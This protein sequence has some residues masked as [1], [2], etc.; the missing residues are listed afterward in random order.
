MREVLANVKAVAALDHSAPMGAMGML[1]NE[2]AGAMVSTQDRPL[3]TN[4]IY[5]LGG[6]DFAVDEAKRI[7]REQKG[8]ADVGYITTEIQ[9]FSGLRGPKLGFYEMKRS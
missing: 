7:F 5:G 2:I 6:R 4:F 1:Y 8:H 9:Q 3:L